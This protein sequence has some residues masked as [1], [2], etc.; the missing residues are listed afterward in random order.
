MITADEAARQ[1]A[2]LRSRLE[3]CDISEFPILKGQIEIMKYV[4]NGRIRHES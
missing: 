1:L 2:V 4:L 3:H